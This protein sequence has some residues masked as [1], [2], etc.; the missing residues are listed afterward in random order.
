MAG[1]VEYIRALW[2]KG[3][4]IIISTA[5]NMATHNNNVGKIIAKQAPVVIEWLK[6]WE[7]PYDEL[8]F[9]KPNA[10]YFI[11]D[12]GVKFTDFETLKKLIPA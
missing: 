11:D 10:D 2:E 7:V 8:H 12:K 3:N 1:A 6:K 4:Y 9:G 5:R